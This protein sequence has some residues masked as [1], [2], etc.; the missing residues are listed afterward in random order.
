[1][2][3]KGMLMGVGVAA[4][5]AA[6]TVSGQPGA[7]PASAPLTACA[8][9]GEYV[10]A[11]AIVGE[12]GPG[13]AGGTLTFTPPGVCEPGAAGTVALNIGHM[14]TGN[15]YKLYQATV[16]YTL[17]ADVVNIGNG[18]LYTGVS[19]VANDTVTSMATIGGG[20]LRLAGTMIRRNFDGFGGGGAGPA[21]PQGLAGP[22]GP[23]GPTGA[24]GLNG[25]QGSAG[26][27]GPVGP[28]GPMGPMGPA[29][30]LGP[31][32][33]TGPQGLVGMMGATGTTGATGA[34]G[35]P[36]AGGFALLSSAS[37]ATVTTV[38]GGLSG[39]AAI[40]PLSGTVAT[41][42]P[43]PSPIGTGSLL[44]WNAQTLP[45]AVSLTSMRAN[46]IVKA[47]LSLV[48]ASVTVQAQLYKG[49]IGGPYFPAGLPCVFTPVFTGLVSVGDTAT[50]IAPLTGLS[51]S[52]GEV[53]FVAIEASAT[54]ITLVNTLPI[55]VSVTLE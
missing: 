3:W 42:A 43:Q 28:V 2:R 38:L 54:G 44:D 1:M 15:A 19:G 41:A 29:G 18:T 9:A 27:A 10:F 47:A 46:L 22:T 35:A 23:P 16:P 53:G 34:T 7:A 45:A 12:P 33:P 52:P 50:C 51:I 20:T 11:A 21:G 13:Q 36:G 37:D 26:T 31:A 6:T 24:A 25:A 4:T 39:I 32:G 55:A 49:L 5:T 14:T 8:I 30:P 17:E 40:L 48:G